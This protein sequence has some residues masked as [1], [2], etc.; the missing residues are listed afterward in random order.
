MR[1]ALES[2]YVKNELG[3][4]VDLYFGKYQKDEGKMT[5]FANVMYEAYHEKPEM[6][7]ELPVDTI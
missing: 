5:I 4:W 3:H 7:E 2:E 1:E 6:Q